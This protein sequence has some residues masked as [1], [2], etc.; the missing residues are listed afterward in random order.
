[1]KTKL[2]TFALL[3]LTSM[4]LSAQ[5]SGVVTNS[6]TSAAIA[7]QTIYLQGDSMSGVYMTTTTN[8]GGQY[9]FTNVGSSYY[10][11]VY[12]YDCNQNYVGQTK[13][14]LPAT[15]N[16]SICNGTS[17]S[18]QAIFNS[19]P[20]SNNA[21]LI[22]FNDAST[23]SPTSWTWNFGDG[24]SSSLQNPNHTYS[25]SG[26]YTVTLSITSAT[27][28]DSTSSQITI[29]TTVC[30]SAFYSV[31]DSSNANTIM[32]FDNSTG[33]PTSWT[34][35][36]G[37]GTSSSLQNPTHTYTPGTY[38][39]T[40]VILGTNC[41]STSTQ[42]IV[43]AGGS[44]T[45]SV[46]GYVMAGSN[47]LDVG[48]I[49]LINASTGA[50]AAQTGL[51]SSSAYHFTNVST[52]NYLVFAIPSPTSV[53]TTYA[54]TYYT[55]S[56]LWSTATTINVNANL[57]SKDVYLFQIVPMAGTGS[58]SGN[59]S[60][61]SKGAVAGAVVNLLNSSN[62]PIASTISD[63]SGNYSFSNIADGT[64]K[65]WAEIAGKTTTPI[66]VTIDANNQNITNNDFEVKNNTVVPKVV[67]IENATQNMQL[68][69][70]PNPVKDQLNIA[71]SLDNNS[72]VTIEIVN[73]T[74]QVVFSNKY[75]LQSGTQTLRMN[76]NNIA[77]GS[78]ILKITNSNGGSTNKLITKIR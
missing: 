75:E 62:N 18:C 47:G 56:I 25:T 72:M 44:T 20:D 77:E 29:G 5:L 6:S 48:L 66:I 52:G 50:V 60:T 67:S 40:L 35:A 33:N 76:L 55:N 71:I 22:Y 61:V 12:T 32:F 53:Y 4:S 69:T 2:L 23:G 30:Q 28:G 64:Y 10:Y 54:A 11:D 68:K 59:L 70:F 15:A 38:T 24:T 41:Q 19:N 43:I 34:W 13:Y 17:T 1:M 46:S 26:T 27:C 78:Y 58:V 8:A 9:S 31:P 42:N 39:V 21:N 14:S 45:Y 7:N 16:F 63:V 65:I 57:T 49:Q 51:D 37:D 36:F 73:L 74:G 3:L